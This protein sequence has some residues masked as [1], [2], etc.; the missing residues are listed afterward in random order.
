MQ[1][2]SFT[3]LSAGGG[4]ERAYSS[5]GSSGTWEKWE[6]NFHLVWSSQTLP[7]AKQAFGSAGSFLKPLFLRSY[8]THGF[9]KTTH[10]QEKGW[11]E[12]CGTSSEQAY[13][14]LGI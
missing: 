4:T 8:L 7:F 3:L 1:P 14:F 11:M 9:T 12:L 2:A 10:V 13:L 5:S 6:G